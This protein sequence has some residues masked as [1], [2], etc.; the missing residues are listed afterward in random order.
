MPSGT[1]KEERKRKRASEAQEVSAQSQKKAKREA[2]SN[3]VVRHDM[4]TAPETQVKI[5][6]HLGQSQAA[7]E[8]EK[9]KS[10]KSKKSKKPETDAAVAGASREQ[11]EG[12]LANTANQGSSVATEEEGTAQAQAEDDSLDPETLKTRKK[13]EKLERKQQKQLEKSQKL[14]HQSGEGGQVGK[15]L[16]DEFSEVIKEHGLDNSDALV[17]LPAAQKD[18]SGDLWRMSLPSGGRYIDHDPVFTEDE[19]SVKQPLIL[20]TATNPFVKIHHSRNHQQHS[21]L[22]SRELSADTNNQS[23]RSHMLRALLAEGKHSLRGHQVRN[24]PYS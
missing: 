7:P 14:E 17:K 4:P 6:S 21:C 23:I 18:G 8:Q 1:S 5:R 24:H 13:Q 12:A 22:R 10:K 2:K 20:R 19:K 16:P 11:E 15:E 3:G 9:Q